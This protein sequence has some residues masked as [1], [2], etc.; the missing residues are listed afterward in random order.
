M[1]DS[2]FSYCFCTNK[3]D[4]ACMCRDSNLASQLSVPLC[5]QGDWVWIGMAD[6]NDQEHN[7]SL[8]KLKTMLSIVVNR[9]VRKSVTTVHRFCKVLGTLTSPWTSGVEERCL[10]GQ[11]WGKESTQKLQERD[12]VTHDGTIQLEFITPKAKP[13]VCRISSPSFHVANSVWYSPDI[14]VAA[15]AAGSEWI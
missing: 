3:K 10:C 14:D 12:D 11:T 4:S 2:P 6:Q 8:P 9:K 7:V 13:L 1:W 5:I 15:A